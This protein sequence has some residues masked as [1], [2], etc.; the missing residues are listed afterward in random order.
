MPLQYRPTETVIREHLG[1]VLNTAHLPSWQRGD[2]SIEL[3]LGLRDSGV[4]SALRSIAP[5]LQESNEW[6]IGPSSLLESLSDSSVYRMIRMTTRT[7]SAL[8]FAWAT[9]EPAEVETLVHELIP[10][11]RARPHTTAIPSI[12]FVTLCDLVSRFG[13]STLLATLKS[14]LAPTQWLERLHFARAIGCTCPSTLLAESATPAWLPALPQPLMR[15]PLTG[16]LSRGILFQDPHRFR[17]TDWIKYVD[18]FAPGVLLIDVDKM[19]QILDVYGM[20]SGDRVLIELAQHLQQLVGDRVIRF[21]GD[22]LLILWEGTG[23]ETVAKAIVES[24]R[25]LAIKTV[26]S[27]FQIM[28]VTVSVGVASGVSA[29]DTLQ[30]AELALHRAKQ[31]GRN[32]FALT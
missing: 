23:L 31:N 21:G 32:Q 24:T 8:P 3:L 11:L 20:T 5:S 18:L 6:S 9:L 1:S 4:D 2:S 22:E 15:D 7:L 28:P 10:S 19:K 12:V 13:T 27:P 26:E 29:V 14:S 25:A 16:L 17:L 30:A